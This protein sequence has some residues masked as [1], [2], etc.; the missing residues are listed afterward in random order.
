MFFVWTTAPAPIPQKL[1]HNPV[2]RD[3]GIGINFRG[4]HLVSLTQL[5]TPFLGLASGDTSGRCTSAFFCF[6]T[7]K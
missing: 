2:P 6:L 3:L 1:S 4:Q 7:Q 5:D